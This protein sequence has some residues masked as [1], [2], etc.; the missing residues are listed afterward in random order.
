VKGPTKT[1]LSIGGKLQENFIV[2]L[3]CNNTILHKW[4]EWTCTEWIPID[5]S[6]YY[7]DTKVTFALT[8]YIHH[9]L[10]KVM[11]CQKWCNWC[12]LL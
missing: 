2:C 4:G 6:N 10:Q 9:I 12:T 5:C 8:L 11:K 1:L 3:N 7:G